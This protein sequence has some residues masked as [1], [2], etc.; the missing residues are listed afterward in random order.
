LFFSKATPELAIIWNIGQKLWMKDFPGVCESLKKEF[1]AEI[2]PI[3]NALLGNLITC[4][5]QFQAV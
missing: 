5:S 2:S 4:E 3:I 1:S